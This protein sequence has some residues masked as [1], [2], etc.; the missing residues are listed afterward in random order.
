MKV[1]L[2][3]TYLAL[4]TGVVSSRESFAGNDLAVAGAAAFLLVGGLVL[5]V[6]AVHRRP[7]PQ[8]EA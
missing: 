7:G 3:V 5:W 4:F 6:W 2:T 1:F 8:D